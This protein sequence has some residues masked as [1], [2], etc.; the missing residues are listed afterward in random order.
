M[1]APFFAVAVYLLVVLVTA[2]FNPRPAYVVWWAAIVRLIAL[3]VLA[4][5]IGALTLFLFGWING[6]GAKTEAKHDSE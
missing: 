4:G 5:A 1:S 3:I 6:V 2:P